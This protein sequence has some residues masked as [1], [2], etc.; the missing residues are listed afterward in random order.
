MCLRFQFCTH[1]RVCILHFLKK[2]QIR[3]TLLLSA[4][5]LCRR[6]WA[7]RFA[8]ATCS[9]L[10][11]LNNLGGLGTDQKSVCVVPARQD[12]Q[13]PCTLYSTVHGLLRNN[14]LCE[15][16]DMWDAT[17][18][19]GYLKKIGRNFYIV[20]GHLEEMGCKIIY[21]EW[22]VQY[23]RFQIRNDLVIDEEPFLLTTLYSSLLYLIYFNKFC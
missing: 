13:S 11:F 2:S 12:T 7:R 4:H 23:L 5:V 10:E 20:L 6:G 14:P 21:S 9:V 16:N 15:E 19:Y 17:G 1:Q 3:C 22:S 8:P 18:T